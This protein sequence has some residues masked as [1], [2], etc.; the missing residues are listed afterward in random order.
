MKAVVTWKG[1][2]L[3]GLAEKAGLAAIHKEAEMILTATIPRTP[4]DEGPLRGSG[5]VTDVKGGSQIG[6]STPY[7]VRQHEDTSLHHD[8][9]E[10][11]FLEKTFDERQKSAVAN[12]GKAIGAVMK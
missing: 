4:I 12:V 1:A 7:A 3:S 10:A 2:A 8:E 11:K 6:F 5:H 9:G